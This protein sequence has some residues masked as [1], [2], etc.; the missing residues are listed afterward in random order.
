MSVFLISH[1]SSVRAF[2]GFGGFVL[3]GLVY[4]YPWIP[5]RISRSLRV[6]ALCA[7]LFSVSFWVFVLVSFCL[8]RLSVV[9]G[10]P[11]AVSRG[12]LSRATLPAVTYVGWLALFAPSPD[13]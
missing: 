5:R 7:L 10:G 2:S 1:I 8:S 9:P 3:V 6:P 11:R 12:A 13:N 4:R